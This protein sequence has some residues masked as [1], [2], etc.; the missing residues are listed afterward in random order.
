VRFP[1]AHQSPRDVAAYVASLFDL[2]GQVVV[3]V[4]ATSGLGAAAA[5]ALGR[6]GAVVTVA[7]R[8]TDRAAAVCD[9]ITRVG[10]TAAAARVDVCDEQSVETLAATVYER[11][12]AVH[13]LVNSAGVFSMGPSHEFDLSDWRQLIDVNLT[14]T[15]LTCRAFGRRMIAAGAGRI[16]NFASTDG[17]VGVPEQAAYCASKGAVIQ[18]TRTLG[19]E[20]IKYGVY[21]NALGPTDFATPMTAALIDDPEYRTWALEAIPMGRIGQPAELIGPLL[22]LATGAASMVVGSTLMVDGGRTVI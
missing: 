12:G 6:C 20:W 16:I 2:S 19:A 14:G 21:V 8:D 11:Y 9:E 15:F 22:L 1:I 13:V 4:G 3:V 7:G 5:V 10:G 18:L 17:V